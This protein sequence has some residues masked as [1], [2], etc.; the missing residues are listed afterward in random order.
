MNRYF[1]GLAVPDELA[2][3]ITALQ[4]RFRAAGE[5]AIKK[6]EPHL[7]LVIPFDTELSAAEL[8]AAAKDAVD[9]TPPFT[10]TTAGIDTFSHRVFYVSV[11]PSEPLSALQTRLQTT[12]AN[13]PDT[14]LVR[15][16]WTFRPHITIVGQLTEAAFTAGHSIVAATPIEPTSWTVDAV[17]LYQQTG[18]WWESV[19][20]IP[21]LSGRA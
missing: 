8:V 21:F 14:H 7:T 9:S 20:M 16:D 15:N 13:R 3:A 10:L 11:A 4:R 1:V 19:Q 17:T 12:I 5:V 6:A 18:E 2:T